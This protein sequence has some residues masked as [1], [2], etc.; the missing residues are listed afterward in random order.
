MHKRKKHSTPHW[1]ELYQWM[2]LWLLHGCASVVRH[3]ACFCGIKSID[4]GPLIASIQRQIPNWKCLFNLQVVFKKHTIAADI[5]IY[6]YV[7]RTSMYS[8]WIGTGL[9]LQRQRKPGPQASKKTSFHLGY[10][11]EAL[12]MARAT[13]TEHAHYFQ[14]RG[15][16]TYG[17][18]AEVLQVSVEPLQIPI[19]LSSLSLCGKYFLPCTQQHRPHCVALLANA[20]DVWEL[21]DGKQTISIDREAFLKAWATSV[22]PLYLVLL[23]VAGPKIED[24]FMQRSAAERRCLLELKAAAG[25]VRKETEIAVS[26]GAGNE[27][28]EMSAENE[29]ISRAG[30]R[31]LELMRL[32]VDAVLAKRVK[33]IQA[34]NGAMV[35]CPHCP[36]RGFHKLNPKRFFAH[37]EKYHVRSRQYCPSGTKQINMLISIF[38]GDRLL[39]HEERPNLL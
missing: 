8:A 19:D 11:E 13:D 9:R 33:P 24:A 1:A 10:V 4:L 21:R 31:I 32:E 18:V 5:H 27:S 39:G 15:Q 34:G 2:S 17:Q 35:V 6:V 30:D 22:D 20:T 36:F 25:P 16:R 12:A 7:C 23:Q 29:S 26:A 37:V 38:D 3:G 28:S 14:R